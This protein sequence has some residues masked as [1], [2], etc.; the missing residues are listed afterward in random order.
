MT[1]LGIYCRKNQKHPN[2]SPALERT[3]SQPQGTPA[4]GANDEPANCEYCY[5]THKNVKAMKAHQ[6]KYHRA[7]LGLPEAGEIASASMT[8]LFSC[9][10]DNMLLAALSR[11]LYLFQLGITTAWIISSEAL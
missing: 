5:K 4:A 1:G 10:F 3:G 2:S 9:Y 7:E 11:L 6:R 8:N